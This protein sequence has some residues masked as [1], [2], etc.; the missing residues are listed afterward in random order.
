MR[1]HVKR[2]SA[3]ELLQR[4]C[5]KGHTRS[6]AYVYKHPFTG[7]IYINCRTCAQLTYARDKVRQNAMRCRRFKE[8]GI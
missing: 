6:D 2:K 1:N 3:R 5:R 8:T 7:K 4:R